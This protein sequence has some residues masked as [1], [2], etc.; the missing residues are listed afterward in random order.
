[1][2]NKISNISKDKEEPQEDYD[3]NNS[4]DSQDDKFNF[5][6]EESKVYLSTHLFLFFSQ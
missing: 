3:Q 1:L 5:S 4:E 6:K 2:N